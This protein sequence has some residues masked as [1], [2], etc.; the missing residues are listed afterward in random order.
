MCVTNV[1]G[2]EMSGDEDEGLFEDNAK[3]SR[4]RKD[5]FDK[6]IYSPPSINMSEKAWVQI[7]EGSDKVVAVFKNVHNQTIIAGSVIAQSGCWSMLKGGLTVNLTS[8][9]Q[10]HF[11]SENS[12]I[13]LWADNISLQP[14]TKDQWIDQQSE[15]I[16]KIRQRKVR[17]H[18]ADKEGKMV[19]GAKVSIEQTRPHFPLGCATAETILTNTAYQDWFTA[20]FKVTTFDNE[21]KWY[22]T[23]TSRGHE[24]YSIPDAM[25]AFTKQHGISVRG[26]NIFWDDPRFQPNWVKSLAPEEFVAAVNNR[27]DSVVLRYSGQVIGWDVVNENVHFSFFEDKLG[28]NASA[29]LFQR[30]QQLDP[31]T[32]MFMNEYNTLEYAKDLNGTPAKY[33]QKLMEIRS[34]PGNEGLLAG[35]GLESHFSEPNIPYMRACLDILG[36]TK[37]PI[38]LTE[39][40]VARGPNQALYL[41]EIMREGYSHPS[42]HG[43]IVWAGWKPT[44]CSRMC[45]T[46]NYFKNLPAGNVVDKLIGEWKIQK[47]EGMTDVNGVYEHHIF[48][49]EYFINVT[50]PYTTISLMQQLEVTN[51]TLEPLDVWI[52]I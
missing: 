35:I 17:F 5:R 11:E 2:V 49:G 14:F 10:L 31:K 1:Y 32:T 29:I 9:A 34:F 50:S 18:V 23:E 25:L 38:W 7:N 33:L 26:H 39:L 12:T 8:P 44:G 22:Y 3:K 40:D 20:R 48:H 4:K 21:I 37:L 13:E 45:L 19:Q 6:S 16:K 27:L 42:V 52:S 43:I 41:E 51:D 36:A 24:N 47:L 28:V 46:D 30:A 15:S